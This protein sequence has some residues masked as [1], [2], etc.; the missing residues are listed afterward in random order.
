[1]DK[2]LTADDLKLL[3]RHNSDYLI[4]ARS[5]DAFRLMELRERGLVERLK[6]RKPKPSL[7]RTSDRGRDAL[8]LAGMDA[9]PKSWRRV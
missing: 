2:P 7:Y 3:Q 1:M 9:E 5:E 6:R 8:R 4:T